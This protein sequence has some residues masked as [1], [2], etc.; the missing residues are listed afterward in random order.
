MSYDILLWNPQRHQ[1][2]KDPQ[3]T[4]L[5]SE[6][7]G[8][9]ELDPKKREVITFDKSGAAWHLMSTYKYFGTHL[10]LIET[11]E[12]DATGDKEIITTHRLVHGKWQ[13][14]RLVKKGVW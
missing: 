13:T 10:K 3:L 12:D 9:I 14:K 8:L 4:K 7:L 2:V 5:S 1:F 6:H 11:V